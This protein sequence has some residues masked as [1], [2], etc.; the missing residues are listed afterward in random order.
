MLS[1]VPRY[2]CKVLVF[3][4]NFNG[5]QFAW[6]IFEKYSN[7]KCHENP[8]SGSRFVPCGRTDTYDEASS[9]FFA[10]LQTHVKTAYAALSYDQIY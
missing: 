2:L 3:L 9:R 7:I 1:N 10:I 6:Q 8:S 5:L 4:S